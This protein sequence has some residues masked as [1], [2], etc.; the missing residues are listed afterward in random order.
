MV[1]PIFSSICQKGLAMKSVRIL[2]VLFIS[3]CYFNS[4]NAATVTI[5]NGT[6]ILSVPDSSIVLTGRHT[7]ISQGTTGI[8]LSGDYNIYTDGDMFLDYSVFSENQDLF[9]GSNISITGQTVTIFSFN[10]SPTLPNLS[11]TSIFTNP[12]YSM[13][14]VGNILLFSEA[15]V[16]SGVFEATGNLYIGNYSSLQPVPLPASAILL[17]SG[18]AMLSGGAAA[19]NRFN[20]DGAKRR[21][22]C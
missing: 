13:N 6:P 21:A 8:Q 22:A 9:I 20:K 4:A 5:G 17:L 12:I 19:N 16:L 10:D 14:E 1:D 11:N 2:P 3:L 15:P 7:D 18:L